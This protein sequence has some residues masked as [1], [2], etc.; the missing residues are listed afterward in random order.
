MNDFPKDRVKEAVLAAFAGT[1][2]PAEGEIIS[3]ECLLID[4]S[5]I[6]ELDR[7]RIVP[8]ER[9]PSILTTPRY[10]ATAQC[11]RDMTPEAF[12]YF[13]PGFLLSALET[14]DVSAWRIADGIS[15]SFVPPS[16]SSD[17]GNKETTFT[18][19]V[20]RL[21][22]PQLDAVILYFNY[23][24]EQSGY[25]GD[26]GLSAILQYLTR[27]RNSRPTEQK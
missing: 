18:R 15:D 27:L 7:L 1:K 8:W 12:A 24:D 2:P 4:E 3:W 10:F 22:T 20:E 25:D 17:R 21:S 26:Q 9:F 13:L 6:E 11:L 23:V 19:R 14:E 16:T 5:L